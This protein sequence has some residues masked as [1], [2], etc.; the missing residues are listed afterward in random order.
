MDAANEKAET[1]KAQLASLG[2]TGTKPTGN[3][4]TGTTNKDNA[5]TGSL[6][7]L[8]NKL[9]DLKKKYKDGILKIT[10]ENYQK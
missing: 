8:E 10:P 7:D 4:G 3:K 9:S 5:V 1:A 6:S 2:G